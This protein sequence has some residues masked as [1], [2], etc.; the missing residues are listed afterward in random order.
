VPFLRLLQNRDS[1]ERLARAATCSPGGY[2]DDRLP[3]FQRRA[4]TDNVFDER[5]P[6]AGEGTFAKLDFSRGA[7]S[8]SQD[9][10]C[11]ILFDMVCSPSARSGGSFAM[12]GCR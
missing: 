6:P 1:A 9:D 11:Q 3:R 4:A 5:G 7:F 2:D 12:K 8:R 10:N